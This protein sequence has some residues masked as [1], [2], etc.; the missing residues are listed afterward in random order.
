MVYVHVARRKFAISRG[1]GVECSLTLSDV[2]AITGQVFLF[3]FFSSFSF[4][5]VWSFASTGALHPLL[6]DAQALNQA[7]PEAVKAIVNVLKT[8]VFPRQ[9]Q[10]QNIKEKKE[11]SAFMPKT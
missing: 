2:R 3:L 8:V 10:K 1:Q 7:L 11:T 4:L 6:H 9:K 5:I